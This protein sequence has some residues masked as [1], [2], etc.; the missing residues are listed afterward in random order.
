MNPPDAGEMRE[1]YKD[2][3]QDLNNRKPLVEGTPANTAKKLEVA[4]MMAEALT[5]IHGLHFNCGQCQ[6]A[7][8]SG[9][10]Q[11]VTEQ[12]AKEALNQWNAL[13]EEK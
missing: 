11:C 1:I 7:M 5:D 13:K 12:I 2:R 6:C 4:E 3:I 10:E 8:T 9:E